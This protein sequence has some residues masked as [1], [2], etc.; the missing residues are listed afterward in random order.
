MKKTNGYQIAIP[1]YRRAAICATTTIAYLRRTNVDLKRVTIFLSDPEEIDFY[2][3]VIK[4]IRIVEG[5]PTLRG[6]RK[7]I[8][9]YYP[10]GTN[11][12][13]MEDDIKSVVE[14]VSPKVNQ[15]VRDLNSVITQGF[16]WI[17]SN[18]TGIFGFAPTDNPFYNYGKGIAFGLRFLD[19]TM[20]GFIAHR[21]K[22][23]HTTQ[24]VKEDYERTLLYFKKYGCVMRYNG[25]GFTSMIYKTKGGLQE[26]NYRNEK[27][28]LASSQ[29]LIKKFP[30]LVSINEK[31]SEAGGM[32]E[33]LL[34]RIG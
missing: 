19:G 31:R 25:I 34:K 24:P 5:V 7:F 12:F 10:E 13:S 1:S 18:K 29:Y 17:R 22:S 14:A 21:D 6:Q 26:G 11:V 3:E 23:L 4:D 32:T 2:K 20:Y 8:N 15:E 28:S 27:N 30:G 9:D 33:I 16:Q